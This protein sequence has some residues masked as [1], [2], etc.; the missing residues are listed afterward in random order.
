MTTVA[1]HGIRRMPRHVN[2]DRIKEKGL[3][4]R[5]EEQGERR[6]AGF[7]YSDIRCFPYDFPKLAQQ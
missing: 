5:V 2:G 1:A 7:C 4:A 3:D 6:Q